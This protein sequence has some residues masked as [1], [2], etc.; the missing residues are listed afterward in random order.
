MSDQ[1]NF[2]PSG[3]NP[4]LV[5]LQ[6]SLMGKLVRL[7]RG[8]QDRGV[9]IVTYVGP[10]DGTARPHESP[11]AWAIRLNEARRGQGKMWHLMHVEVYDDSDSG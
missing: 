9:G 5:E 4:T 7:S 8:G 1:I 3:P 2:N 11:R 10:A 6:K